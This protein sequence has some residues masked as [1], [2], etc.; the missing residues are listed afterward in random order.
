MKKL[1]ALAMAGMGAT[2]A[3]TSPVFAEYP[4]DQT[5]R[6]VIPFPPG[7]TT[8][9]V[10]RTLQ[11]YFQK[12]LGQNIVIVNM[13]GAGGAVGTQAAIDAKP[14][15]YTLGTLQTNTMIAQ[16]VGLGDYTDE[17]YVPAASIGFMP[18]A[19][20]VKGDSPIQN[21]QEFKAAA[22]A[23]P[24][25]IGVAMG[26]GTLAHF[27]AQMTENALGEDLKLINAGGGAKKKAAVLGG[28]STSMIDPPPGVLG[29]HKSGEARIIAVFGPERIGPLPDVP[30]AKEQGVDLE[31]FQ[32]KGFFVPKGTP[33]DVIQKIGNALCSLGDN[34]ELQGKLAA[35]AVTWRCEI[36]GDY[37]T[38]VDDTRGDVNS[39]AKQMGY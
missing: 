18:L 25:E 17:D 20:T 37:A 15:G 16:A 38:W 36:G 35:L 30:T 10:F 8:D 26:V 22:K 6:I 4:A 32:M 9:T 31:A 1:V 13:K 3:L 7:G 24:G 11:P 29:L 23:A 21:L 33:G 14:D 27:V 5:V 12:A 2:L 19:I 34:A 28:H 39:L